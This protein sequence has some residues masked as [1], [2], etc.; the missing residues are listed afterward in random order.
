M[1]NPSWGALALALTVLAGI[2]TWYAYRRR[3]LASGMRGLAITLLPIAA[4]L[5]HTLRLLGRIGSAIGSWATGFIFNPAVWVGVAMGGVAVVLFVVAGQLPGG[6]KA[7]KPAKGSAQ[8]Q[9][10]AVAS[11]TSQSG[12]PA[13]GGDDDLSDIQAILKKHGI[14]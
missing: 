10:K 3:G 5:T 13:L 14:S 2:W 8:P 4:Y 7:A 9:A 1:D 11:R 6:S 12:A